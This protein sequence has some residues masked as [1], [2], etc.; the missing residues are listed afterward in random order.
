M[1]KKRFQT[2]CQNFTDEKQKIMTLWEEIEN[3]YSDPS[4]YYH[5][6][7]HLQNIYQELE[8]FLD[9]VVLEFSIFYHD[10][11]YKI[12][13]DDNEEQ[14]A[15]LAEKRL[16]ALDVDFEIIKKVSRLINETKSHQP[17]S[18]TNA[19]FLDADLS[20]LGANDKRY[21]HYKEKIRKEYAFYNDKD[22]KIGRQRVLEYFMERERIY[23]SNY[24]YK[25]Y[26]KEAQ[27][28]IIIE[29]NSLI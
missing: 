25:K 12:D 2:L 4:R 19:L 22:Y 5:S 6:L 24:F 18:M 13:R 26:E 9:D 10:I 29:Y 8:P 14:S 28:N 11:V 27:Q 23:E 3:A 16:S 21:Q 15:I 17:T 1:L 20:I 7:E